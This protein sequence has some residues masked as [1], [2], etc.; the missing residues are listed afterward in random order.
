MAKTSSKEHSSRASEKYA[1][2]P[3][4]TARQRF[5]RGLEQPPGSFRFSADALLLAAFLTADDGA[6]VL[7]IGTG[8]GVVALAMLCANPRST[9]TGLDR[10]P[11][12]V[13]TA[14]RNAE[15]LGVAD[16]FS[17]FCLDVGKNEIFAKKQH[18][19]APCRP[20][21]N[22][23]SG[24][25]PGKTSLPFSTHTLPPWGTFDIVLA[26]PPYRK[27][28]CGRLPENPLRRAALFEEEN[29]LRAFCRCAFK[30]IAPDGRFG[31]I[32]PWSR[33]G[34]LKAAI[35]QAGLHAARI[36]EI[37]T[38]PEPEPK[39]VLVES[40]KHPAASAILQQ[41]LLLYDKD[42]CGKNTLTGE[43]RD[44]CPWLA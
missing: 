17:S 29:T 25:L 23:A 12:L 18:P 39:F 24:L 40:S 31:V 32:Y 22:V 30:A 3:A 20:S 19:V 41:S 7:D 38:R 14:R 36:L 26:N 15:R 4:A 43:A 13:E 34:D 11:L 16:R 44:F 5:P 27:P 28:Q 1:P 8:C 10:E 37:R 21:V 42:C 9:A 6:K 2:N 33:L 35:L